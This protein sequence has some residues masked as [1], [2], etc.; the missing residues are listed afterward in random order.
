[1]TSNN[2]LQQLKALGQSVWLDFIQRRFLESG[3]LQ[4]LI[5]DDGLASMTSSPA[6]FE[7]AIAQT[8]EYDD[9][10]KQL[11]QQGFSAGQMYEQISLHD[12]QTAADIFRPVY[13]NTAGRD[14]YV[15]L[16][17]SP[18]LAHDT[19]GTV[20]EGQRLWAQLD[21]PNVMIKVPATLAGLPAIQQ[22]IAEGINVNVTLLFSV[23]RYQTVLDAYL[24]GLESRLAQKQSIDHIASVASFFVSRTDTLVD[25]LLDQRGDDAAKA[26]RGQAAVASARL[27]YQHYRTVID[28]PRWQTLADSGAKTQRLLW[29]STGTKDPYYS[30]VKYVEELIGPETVNTMPPK[31]LEAYR[32]Q[33]EPA[34]RLT[35]DLPT[36]Q[37]IPAQLKALNIDLEAVSQ[38]LEVEGVDK[39]IQPFDQL[40]DTLEQQRAALSA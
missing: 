13:E 33:G 18:H 31:T 26:L 3:D 35:A 12:V 40:M 27:A 17:V 34:A 29:A 19:A 4:R 28:S 25:S 14:G 6:I 32:E 5:N 36:M 22:L 1:M 8:R 9:T 23:T 2:P 7:Q 30:P 21:R 37:A 10:I 20:A 11:A 16:E 24:V 15:S 39:F 38:Q